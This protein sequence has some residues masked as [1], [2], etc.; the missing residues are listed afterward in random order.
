[1]MYL[2]YNFF[3]SSVYKKRKDFL[4]EE[5]IDL[6]KASEHYDMSFILLTLDVYLSIKPSIILIF[7][8]E[9]LHFSNILAFFQCSC[10]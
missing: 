7:T 5:G 3:C 1:M 10:N 9:V 2:L 6:T 8:R 4:K